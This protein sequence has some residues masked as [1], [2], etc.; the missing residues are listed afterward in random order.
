M[1]PVFFYVQ[2]V[3]TGLNVEKLKTLLKVLKTRLHY[4]FVVTLTRRDHK[5]SV[6]LL[7]EHN[8]CKL[9]RKCHFRH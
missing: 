8:P 4:L 1:D 7:H 5:C 9:M 6:Y 3:S 2:H